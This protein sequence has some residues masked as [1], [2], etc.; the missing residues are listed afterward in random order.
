MFFNLEGADSAYDQDSLET[1]VQK[2]PGSCLASTLAGMWL[3]WSLRLPVWLPGSTSN[4]N[5]ILVDLAS[6]SKA[7]GFYEIKAFG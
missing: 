5:K 3:D 1:Q 6:P 7:L 4:T 2:E